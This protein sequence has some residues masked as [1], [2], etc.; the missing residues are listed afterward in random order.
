M[1]GKLCFALAFAALLLSGCKEGTPA[2]AETTPSPQ[3]PAP[4]APLEG[5]QEA[6]SQ[7]LQPENR[8]DRERAREEMH[9]VGSVEEFYALCDVDGDEIPELLIEYWELGR[10]YIDLYTWREE[11]PTLAGTFY[12]GRTDS[13]LYTHPEE[14]GLWNK[15]VR[16]DPMGETHWWRKFTLADGVLEEQ[17]LLEEQIPWGEGPEPP[18]AYAPTEA[19]ELVPGAREVLV[20]AIPDR[21]QH[22]QL[23][24]DY[25]A[26]ATLQE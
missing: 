15:A 23:I 12:S 8:Q 1:K 20:E 26:P 16:A 4:A 24:L 19:A 25:V 14:V 5:W 7:V 18:L 10:Y 9:G 2:A 17:E 21:G 11:T 22:F 13:R 6:Y 3:T